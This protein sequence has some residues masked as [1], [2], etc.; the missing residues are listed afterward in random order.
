MLAAR[1]FRRHPGQPVRT[2]SA[3]ALESSTL[4]ETIGAFVG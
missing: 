4:P 2:A 1:V 3:I